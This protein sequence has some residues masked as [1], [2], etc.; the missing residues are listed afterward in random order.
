MIELE[1][2][3]MIEIIHRNKLDGAEKY[4]SCVSCGKERDVYKIKFTDN[5]KI[6]SS[7]SLCEDCMYYL[8][9]E[10]FEKY[11]KVWRSKWKKSGMTIDAA[12]PV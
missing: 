4:G 3:I 6:S 8:G 10:I 7:I 2:I 12:P 9:N 11:T 1:E 5:N